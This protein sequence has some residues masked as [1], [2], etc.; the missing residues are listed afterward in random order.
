MADQPMPRRAPTRGK[1][2]VIMCTCRSGSAG[3]FTI[4]VL[5]GEPATEVLFVMVRSLQS[6]YMLVA[7][8][9]G[10]VS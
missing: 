10:L 1:D 6:R 3:V 4:G 8:I 9:F 5:R 2:Y 7:V